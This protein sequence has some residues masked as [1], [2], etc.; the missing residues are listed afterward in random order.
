MCGRG[1]VFATLDGNNN[2]VRAVYREAFGTAQQSLENMRVTITKAAQPSIQN[3][4][5]F[6]P[7]E[8]CLLFP[9]I[10]FTSQNKE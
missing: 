10:N 5:G 7:K 2:T 8:L 6:M 3:I 1:W 9:L 4:L